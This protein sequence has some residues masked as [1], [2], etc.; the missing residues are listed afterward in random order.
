MYH[1]KDGFTNATN[2]GYNFENGLTDAE[3]M[4]IIAAGQYT[5]SVLPL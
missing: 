2:G 3:M 5:A 4:K 1:I